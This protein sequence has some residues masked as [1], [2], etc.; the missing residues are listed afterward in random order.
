[1]YEYIIYASIVL[2]VLGVAYSIVLLYRVRDARFGF[3]T[4]M[5]TLMAARQIATLRAGNPGLAELPGL[6]VSVFA[7]LTVVYL[8][9]YVEQEAEFTR[10]IRAKNDR[11]RTF[12]K[13]I[14]H[15]GHAIFLTDPDGTI[16][17]ANRAV[18]PVTGYSRGEVLG[19]DPSMWKS[20]EH[21][22]SFYE[23]L[24]ETVLDGEVWEGT[25]INER[26][27]GSKRW[28]D[29]TIAPIVDDGEVEQFVA[30]DTDVTERRRREEKIADQKRR[31][32]ELNHTNR[33][34]RDVNRNLVQADTRAEIESGVTNEFAQSTPYEAAWIASRNVTN[35]AVR[36]TEWTGIERDDLESLI[37]TF[38][39]TE[40]DPISTA[41]DE[42]AVTV[43]SCDQA[44]DCPPALS[45]R[46]YGAIAAVPLKHGNA[47]YGALCLATDDD[48]AFDTIESAVFSELGRTIGYAI[49]AIESRETLMDDAVTEI[50]FQTG[51]VECF[52]VGMSAELGC[53]LEL[54]WLSPV[55]EESVVEYFAIEGA[56]PDAIVEYAENDPAIEDVDVISDG[57]ES[58]FRFEVKT[59]CVAGSVGEFGAD[60]TDIRVEN[61]MAR[62]TAHLSRGG[63]VR[64]L[65]EALREDHGDVEMLARRE[66][67]RP[68]RSLQEIRNTL[69]DELTERQREALQTAFIGGFFD[70][71]REH[72]GE[73]I[74]AVMGISQ[75]TFLQHLRVAER[76]VLGATLESREEV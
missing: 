14:E 30:V 70:W 21:D 29:M 35:D 40:P 38:N 58:L 6:I 50:V 13:A 42:T 26:K 72:S 3:L 37:R 33:V 15:A 69:E 57:D 34:I 45:R 56:D 49:S 22:E 31:L 62:V 47:E 18:E 5:L 9:R 64:A 52:S 71:P 24:W 19:E 44:D 76:K 54:E 28:V 2:R 55:D 74:A 51:D 11:L 46:G 25:I 41:I 36:P 59:S 27:D 1:M 12:R 63:D 7:L 68:K 73:E 20:G 39:E 23:D 4:A 60:L 65:L 53:S 32:E 48:T 16:T 75:S 43:I 8:A 66:K 67:E 10:T 17:Y 61:G